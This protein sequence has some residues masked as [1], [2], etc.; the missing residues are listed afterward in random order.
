ALRVV[1]SGVIQKRP[2]MIDHRF[3]LSGIPARPTKP[4]EEGLTLML[5]KG[6]AQ[7]QV[8]DLLD[9]AADFVDLVKLGWGTAVITPDLDRKLAIYRDAGVPVYFGGTLFEAFFLRGNIDGYRRI[10]D[11][12]GIH[13]VEVSDGSVSMPHE[14]K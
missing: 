1:P 8:E 9:V 6:M 7:R 4:R 12:L 13:H 14:E 5:D 3:E 11:R 10:L 2:A